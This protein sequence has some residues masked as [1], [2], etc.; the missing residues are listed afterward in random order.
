MPTT[1]YNDT[2]HKHGVTHLVGVQKYWYDA[3]GNAER[4]VNFGLDVNY[5][6][7]A[8][9]RLTGVSGSKTGAFTYDGDGKL[10]KTQV[11]GIYVAIVGTHYQY[12]GS[13][14]T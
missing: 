1:A 14:G 4:R 6:Y 7:D 10:V 5:T 3:N 12:S 8:E 2:A 11:S 9:N 13:T